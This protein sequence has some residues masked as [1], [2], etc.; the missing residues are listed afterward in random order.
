MIRT[1]LTTRRSLHCLQTVARPSRPILTYRQRHP[2]RL[3]MVLAVA[4]WAITAGTRGLTLAPR[5]ALPGRTLGVELLRTRPADF[6]HSE[7]GPRCATRPA[8]LRSSLSRHS[9]QNSCRPG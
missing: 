3:T 4:S 8:G 2:I 9:K 7:D 5:C 1:T 6:D